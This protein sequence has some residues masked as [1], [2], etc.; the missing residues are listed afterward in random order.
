MKSEPDWNSRARNAVS[1]GSVSDRVHSENSGGVSE[2]TYRYP[3]SYPVAALP[4]LTSLRHGLRKLVA[5]AFDVSPNP[6]STLPHTPLPNSILDLLVY[7]MAVLLKQQDYLSAV[8]RFVRDEVTK[9]GGRVRFEALYLAV[10][11]ETFL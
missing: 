11:L 3:I 7:V 2:F 4:V 6:R 1:T 8:M 5:H 10:R 9:K